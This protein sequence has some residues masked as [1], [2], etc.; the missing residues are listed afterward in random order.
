M[1]LGPVQF[2]VRV[3][4]RAVDFRF[5]V[6]SGVGGQSGLRTWSVVSPQRA[7]TVADALAWFAAEWWVLLAV[8]R[9]AARARLDRHAWQLARALDTFLDRQARRHEQLA[10]W[11]TARHAAA[12]LDYEAAQAAA[13]RRLADAHHRLAEFTEAHIRVEL[14]F[15]LDRRRGDPVGQAATHHVMMRPPRTRTVVPEG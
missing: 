12:R 11:R 2:A 9:E 3:S 5:D 8:H 15:D 14:A 7:A 10:A 6:V 13:C 4:F 1:L